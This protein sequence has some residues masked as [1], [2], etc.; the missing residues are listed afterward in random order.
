MKDLYD[1]ITNH[2]SLEQILVVLLLPLLGWSLGKIYDR[3]KGDSIFSNKRIIY[4][5]LVCSLLG[6]ISVTFHC[7]VFAWLIFST[8]IVLSAFL[9]F[10][11]EYFILRFGKANKRSK[12]LVT[13]PALLKFYWKLIKHTSDQ[14]ERQDVKL[15]FLNEIRL[16]KWEL[17]DYEYRKYYI[18]ILKVYYDIGAVSVTTQSF[19]VGAAK[20]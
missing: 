7:H 9:P 13:T 20:F 14:L 15:Q 5:L 8:M 12:W 10:P 18:E 16:R 17:F 6:L 3:Y 1:L 11:H 19:F 2:P 4:R